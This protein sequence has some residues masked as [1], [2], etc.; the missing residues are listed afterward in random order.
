MVIQVLLR[1]SAIYIVTQ[2]M[3]E[4]DTAITSGVLPMYCPPGSAP[5]IAGVAYAY[6]PQQQQQQA[7]YNPDLNAAPPSYNDVVK[8]P[9][10]PMKQ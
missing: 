4:L 10:P 6:V 3:K 8:E 5:I 1:A 7:A 2:F 9:P